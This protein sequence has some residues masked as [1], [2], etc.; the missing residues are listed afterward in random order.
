MLRRLTRR[1]QW[2]R[3]CSQDCCCASRLN[4]DSNSRRS[5]WNVSSTA[6]SFWTRRAGEG[7]PGA[8]EA[9]GEPRGDARSWV[10][11]APAATCV[12]APPRENVLATRG[13][14]AR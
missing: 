4:S 8:S 3:H 6:R 9:I 10:D 14:G 1:R 7:G 11:I 5:A 13:R 12:E 2:S